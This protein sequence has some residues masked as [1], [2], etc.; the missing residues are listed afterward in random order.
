MGF[1]GCIVVLGRGAGG[2]GRIGEFGDRRFQSRHKAVQLLSGTVTSVSLDR[3]LKPCERYGLPGT[4][5]LRNKMA[6]RRGCASDDVM[7]NSERG[8][9]DWQ[10]VGQQEARNVLKRLSAQAIARL[11]GV[12]IVVR[13][14]VLPGR[15][16]D[17]LRP[18]KAE[19]AHEAP[20]GQT[21]VLC[22]HAPG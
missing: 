19:P 1:E 5:A 2:G 14:R 10:P 3:F 12:R 6:H 11:F 8:R 9:R 13:R 22:R 18:A 4:Y 15:A 7:R 21:I 20:P 17:M 16:V